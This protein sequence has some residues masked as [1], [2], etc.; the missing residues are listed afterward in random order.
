VDAIVA[1]AHGLKLN[2]IAEGVETDPQLEYLKS[3]GCAEIQGW[4]FGKA[5]SAET[6][7]KIL[8]RIR[9]G[10]CIRSDVAA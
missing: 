8:D 3:L 1:M 7:S 4:L 6:T 9:H 10:G 2:L 5:E